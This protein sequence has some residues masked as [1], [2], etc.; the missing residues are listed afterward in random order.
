MRRAVGAAVTRHATD[1][2]A[3]KDD[4]P[5]L[6]EEDIDTTLVVVCPICEREVMTQGN[7]TRVWILPHHL[8]ERS[9]SASGREVRRKGPNQ[10][11]L[12]NQHSGIDP[13]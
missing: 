11:G 12:L 5:L 7:A 9:C 1:P 6:V 3:P 8:A 4:S 2:L 13:T 10:M